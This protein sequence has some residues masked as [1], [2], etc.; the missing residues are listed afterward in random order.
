MAVYIGY[1][2]NGEDHRPV[3]VTILLLST[4]LAAEVRQEETLETV[5]EGMARRV[6]DLSDLK[7]TY[8]YSSPRRL[9]NS[10]KKE[11]TTY[12]RGTLIYKS[13]GKASWSVYPVYRYQPFYA[14]KWHDRKAGIH[15]FL[16]P[17][18]FLMYAPMKLHVPEYWGGLPAREHGGALYYRADLADRSPSPFALLMGGVRHHPCLPLLEL[19]PREYFGRLPNLKLVGRREKEGREV[20]VLKTTP[21]DRSEKTREDESRRLAGPT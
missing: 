16:N 9:P 11:R 10:K 20:F 8:E 6:K 15:C 21:A 13:G 1:G 5:L 4:L 17:R 2:K 3:N 7:L 19:A 14:Q 12:T 18:E